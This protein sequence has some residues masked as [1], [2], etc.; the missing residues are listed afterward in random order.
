MDFK[1]IVK[2][3]VVLALAVSLIS[4]VGMGVIDVFVFGIIAFVVLV[5]ACLSTIIHNQKAD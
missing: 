2:R 3:G 5:L 4:L 1:K